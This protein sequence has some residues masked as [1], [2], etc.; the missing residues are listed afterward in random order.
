[1]RILGLDPGFRK[2][3]WG[4]IEAIENRLTYVSSGT[5]APSPSQDTAVRLSQLFDGV[6]GVVAQHSPET[7][8]VEEI[9]VSRN[10]GS[11]LK[12]GQARGV[13]MLAPAQAGLLVTEYSANKI[14]KSVVGAGHAGKQQIQ[15]MVKMLLP[16][17]TPNSEDAADAL[18]TA[19]C[20]AHHQATQRLWNKNGL[21]AAE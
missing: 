1:M 14:K 21:E 10:A 4:I 18:A 20:H 9:F 13:V 7:A 6:A 17:A 11:A 8:A 19:I 3:G 12:L 15:A 5:I 16:L 2:T